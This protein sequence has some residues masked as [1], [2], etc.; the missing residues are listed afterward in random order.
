MIYRKNKKSKTLGSKLYMIL[1]HKNSSMNRNKIHDFL[2]LGLNGK[3]KWQARI[4]ERWNEWI[5]TTPPPPPP[6]TF[7]EP[8]FF[9]FSFFLLI[10]STRLWFYY[11]ITKIHPPLQNPGSAPERR[12]CT[13]TYKMPVIILIIRL[14]QWA[15]KMNRILC[16]DWLPARDYSPCP[17]RKIS[18][19]AIK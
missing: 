9:F 13:S 12:Q 5:F 16:C 1:R 11:I 8:P 3:T 4:Q 2:K 17:A 19:K 15:G 7:S 6:P 10:T 14:A 18:P